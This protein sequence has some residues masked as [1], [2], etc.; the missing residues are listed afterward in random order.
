[1]TEFAVATQILIEMLFVKEYREEA[2]TS[3][4]NVYATAKDSNQVA[5]AE[6]LCEA[7]ASSSCCEKAGGCHD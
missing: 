5:S 4:S 2:R 3:D 6:P 7:S 1:M